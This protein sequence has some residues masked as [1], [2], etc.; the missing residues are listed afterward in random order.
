MS[1]HGPTTLCFCG[2][3]HTVM[4]RPY[5]ACCFPKK[6]GRRCWISSIDGSPV[7]RE[8]HRYRDKQVV[9]AGKCVSNDTWSAACLGIFADRRDALLV[10]PELDL[11]VHRPL[12]KESVPG[13]E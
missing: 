6:R 9:D 4:P 7:V 5:K 3:R 13:V 2:R 10:L 11:A 8:L 12:V 1:Y